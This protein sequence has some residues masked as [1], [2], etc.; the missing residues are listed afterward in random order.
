MNPNTENPIFQYNDLSV[1]EKPKLILA[2]QELLRIL[3]EVNN[4]NNSIK[5]INKKI[6]QEENNAKKIETSL[7]TNQMIGCGAVGVIV[8]LIIMIAG[9][10]YAE[11]SLGIIL[12]ISAFAVIIHLR[13]ISNLFP[14]EVQKELA[15]QYRKEHIAPLLQQK[16]AMEENFSKYLQ[17]QEAVWARYALNDRYLELNTVSQLLEFLRCGRADSLK[18]ALNLYEEIAHRNRMER[19]Q[20]SIM[21]ATQ[22]TATQSS[23]TAQ[24]A[25]RSANA[26][27][28]AAAEARKISQATNATAKE[29]KEIKRAS[30][31]TAAASVM[32]ALNI[33][34][35]ANRK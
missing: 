4:R 25:L 35:M 33:H 30:N 19:M 1:L 15:N 20:S 12:L 6:A 2:L 23:I 31:V 26:N 18:E 9:N 7:S 32:S 16:A 27:E 13:L 3:N 22:Y 11:K 24:A 17:T 28:I 29:A 8:F 10:S 34:K 5:A 21:T 14:S